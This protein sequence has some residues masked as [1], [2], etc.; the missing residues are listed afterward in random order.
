MPASWAEVSILSRV[1]AA[2]CPQHLLMDSPLG[3]C[4][5]TSVLDTEGGSSGTW[6]LD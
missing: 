5:V 6:T 4:R 2:L 1:L 3:F